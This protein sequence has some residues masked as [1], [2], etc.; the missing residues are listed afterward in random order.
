MPCGRR[1]LR[2]L[3][4]QAE[5]GPPDHLNLEAQD[6]WIRLADDLAGKKLLSSGDVAAFAAYCQAYG[7]W[8]QAERALQ[9]VAL[10]DATT[11]GLMI[12]TSNATSSRTR[13]SRSPTG[14]CRM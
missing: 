6:E 1:R 9:Q 3:G 5:F 11:A 4:D 10:R 12:R 2:V 8:V 14:R 7:R 13:C